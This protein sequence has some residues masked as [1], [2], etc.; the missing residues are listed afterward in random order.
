M[1]SAQRSFV[2]NALVLHA[3]AK[4]V[5][6]G[7]SGDASTGS[8]QVALARYN[9]DG[10]VDASFATGGMVL[11]PVGV[12]GAQANTV[13]LQPDGMIL[14]AGTAFAHGTENDEFFIARYTS[15]GLLDSSFGTAGMTTTHVGAGASAASAIALQSDGHILVAGTAFSNGPTDDDFAVVR[16]TPS[17]HLDP[18]FGTAGTVT[19]DFS[20][21]DSGTSRSLDRASTIVLQPDGK[22]VV[23]GFTRGERQAFAA[24][25][26]NP[27]GGL[28]SGFGH[29]GKVLVAGSEPLVSSIV[30]QSS[31]D[32]VL[33]GNSASSS[34]GTAPFALV[35]LHADGGPDETFGSG[36]LVTTTFEGSRSGARAVVAQPDGKLIAGGAKFGAPT[37]QGDAV[38]DSGFALAR[39]TADGRIDSTFGT[40]GKALTDVGDAGA[41]P[42]SLAVQTDGKILV[43]GLVF[44]QVATPTAPGALDFAL[45]V[46]RPG[47]GLGLAIAAIA[48]AVWLRRGKTR[49]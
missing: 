17:G 35:R 28:D 33:A 15:G 32:I 13:A 1:R 36:G 39:Y 5:I 38:P 42:L 14:V 2:A 8:V 6:G 29:G 49:H 18:G 21:P 47:A 45:R 23:A 40:A 48:A 27:D 37:A 41:T 31:G 25:R 3:D 43:A 20:S 44:F 22:I 12:A 10:S 16:Y 19:T 30:L 9:P 26:Y 11:S 24:A 34:R 7:L 4:I 46:A